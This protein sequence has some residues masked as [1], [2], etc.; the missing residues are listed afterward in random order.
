M[1][2]FY[3]FAAVGA[4]Y[5]NV[6]VSAMVAPANTRAINGIQFLVVLAI[7]VLVPVALVLALALAFPLAMVF[8]GLISIG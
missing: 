5:W 4:L 7:I 2:D 1:N 8:T 3:L 6:A